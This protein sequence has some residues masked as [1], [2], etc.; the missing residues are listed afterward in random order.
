[1]SRPVERKRVIVGCDL[2]DVLAAFMPKFIDM[3]RKAGFGPYDDRMPVDWAWSNMGW[4]QEQQDSLWKQLAN[5]TDFWVEDIQPLPQVTPNLVKELSEYT[6]MYFPTARANSKGYDVG[7]QSARW[8]RW[9]FG[10]MY[11]TVIVSNEKGPLAAALKYDYFIDDRPK[12]VFEVKRARPECK[13]FLCESSHNQDEETRLK[14]QSLGIPRI[15]GF[16]EFAK[17]ILEEIHGEGK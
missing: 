14:C 17:M 2:D 13:V 4:T 16:N 7:F 8:L 15:A 1:M 6:V 3:A 12:N 9:Q 10:S 11:P 5:T